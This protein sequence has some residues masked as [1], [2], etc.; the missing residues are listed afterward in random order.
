MLNTRGLFGAAVL[1]VSGCAPRGVTLLVSAVT[2]LRAADD[3]VGVAIEVRQGDSR[4][5]RQEVVAS[6]G[7][8]VTPRVVAELDGLPDGP[9]T[10]TGVL[11]G[12]GRDTVLE[13][14]TVDSRSG[15]RAVTLL[16]EAGCYGVL[17]PGEGQPVEWTA[18]RGGECMEPCEDCP[19]QCVGAEDCPASP[20]CGP[21][22]CALG[23]CIY[24]M[25]A[26]RCASGELCHPVRGCVSSQTVIGCVVDGDC[27]S[28]VPGAF[29]P[30]EGTTV[31][32]ATGER[33][34]DVTEFRCVDQI[35][36]PET[37]LTVEACVRD[38]EGRACAEERCDEWTECV[39][40]DCFV[41][42]RRTQA[43]YASVCRAGECIEELHES[44]LG[45]TRPSTDGMEC[46][47]HSGC[48]GVCRDEGCSEVCSYCGGYCSLGQ[49]CRGGTC[50]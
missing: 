34:R 33:E 14:T 6:R 7:D 38:V 35:C 45:C 17:C 1:L 47:P 25:G 23:V 19:A 31:C 40:T 37:R 15:H 48:R 5:V 36:T 30:C 22:A 27:P 3:F 4:V 28:P 39:F 8:W 49:G 42:G 46:S 26:E 11:L 41:N 29:G 9:L 10:V 16:F 24:P 44:E 12:A 21:A 13:T 43:C 18:C 32:A 50:P 2:D 20:V